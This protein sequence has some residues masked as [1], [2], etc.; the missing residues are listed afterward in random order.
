MKALNVFE[1]DVVISL[2]DMFDFQSVSSHAKD[3]EL[4]IR[5]KDELELGE[6]IFDDIN[7][8]LGKRAK[9]VKK[10][11]IE[12]NHE[13]RLFRDL[14][15]KNPQFHGLLDVPGLLNLRQRGWDFTPY[16]SSFKYGKIRLT[17][18]VGNA[19]RDAARKAMALYEGSM[20]MGHTHR[21]EMSVQGRIDG[22]PKVG[23]MFGHL[24]DRSKVKYMHKDKV[25]HDWVHGFGLGF[26]DPRT[27]IVHL[28]PVPIVNGTCCVL[29]EI[30]R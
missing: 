18:E 6:I 5:L 13:H 4:P 27:G 7:K 15:N 12:G 23:I 29:G 24:A 11:L 28:Q 21:L 22:P 16:N 20:A 30:I 14:W 19:G 10:R 8:A 9:K 26:K 17:H 25:T 3:P 1:P 2:G